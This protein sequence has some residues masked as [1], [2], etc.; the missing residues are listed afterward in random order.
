MKKGSHHSVETIQRMIEKRNTP[1]S[2]E[3]NR[4]KHLG[5]PGRKGK[6]NGNY[7][8]GNRCNLIQWEL[9]VKRR[10]NRICQTCG[11]ENLKGKDCHAHHIFKQEKHLQFRY[12]LWN[13]VTLCSSCHRIIHNTGDKE[14][15]L[16]GWE[17]RRKRYTPEEISSQQR[18]VRL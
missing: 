4:L 5:Q 8:D 1:E 15:H 7:K 14:F 10:D 3:N 11:R 6:D 18:R 12:E 2:I 13:G 17:T 16:K 9:D